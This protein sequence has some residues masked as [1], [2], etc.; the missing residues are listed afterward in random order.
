[1]IERAI[2]I[3]REES[4]AIDVS[5]GIHRC[6]S[7][8]IAADRSQSI[9]RRSQSATTADGFDR[10]RARY[11]RALLEPTLSLCVFLTFRTLCA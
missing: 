10:D 8:A 4:T 9:A 6:A 3:G 7:R 2:A 11:S 5:N 1:M